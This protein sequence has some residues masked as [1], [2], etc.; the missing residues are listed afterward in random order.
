MSTQALPFPLDQL[1]GL[2]HCDTVMTPT[3]V[4]ALYNL[5]K[6]DK[7]HPDNQLGIY[8]FADQYNQ[9]DMDRW[10]R[11]FAPEIP[12]GTHPD[13]KSVDGGVA[14]G[15]QGAG[16][17]SFLDL[18][19]AYP[20]LH[21]QGIVLYQVEDEVYSHGDFDHKGLF[22]NFLD[23][24][25]GSYCDYSAY[26]ET[27]NN[28][29]FDFPY[30]DPAPGGYKGALQCGVYQPTNVLSVSY[31][32]AE[33]QLPIPYQRRQCDEW[34][35]LGLRGVSVVFASGDHGVGGSFGWSARPNFCLGPDGTVFNPAWPA[36]C[37][38]VTAAGATYLPPGA[39][40]RRDEEVA[41]YVPGMKS[42]GGFS[43]IFPTPAYQR[44]AVDRYLEVTADPAV[45]AYP[46]YASTAY[47]NDSFGAG[48]G[49]YNRAGRAYPDVGAAGANVA[50]YGDNQ[51]SW[52][53]AGTSVSAPVFAAVLTRI[54]EERLAAGKTTVGFVN[55]VLYA[56]PEVL[57]DITA[58]NN[59]ACGSAGFIASEGWDPVTGLGTP[60]YPA[61]LDLWMSLP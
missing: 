23:S 51:T 5:T 22:N 37:P 30:P 15:P 47:A 34:M 56:H 7:A 24:I 4:F 57:R 8:E 18:Q 40:A 38:Y 20:L 1:K 59:S 33:D 3:C 14:P 58:G 12:N 44:A 35:K 26:G 54:N 36:T 19:I 48:G 60:D 25:D 2:D 31:A 10:F 21:P 32:L 16:F 41:A 17:E 28:P 50:L 29:D 49:L 55:P 9:I 53:N 11:D 6:P 13:V 52:P 61:M 42:G 39:D 45:R 46:S 27:G 43:N